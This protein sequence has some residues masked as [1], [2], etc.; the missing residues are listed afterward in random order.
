MGSYVHKRST[1]A[2]IDR[3]ARFRRWDAEMHGGLQHGQYRKR[4]AFWERLLSCWWL[5]WNTRN[6]NTLGPAQPIET[7]EPENTVNEE[8]TPSPKPNRAKS[9][10]W[11]PSPPLVWTAP[12]GEALECDNIKF[13]MP[14][15]LQTMATPSTTLFGPCGSPSALSPA[16]KK[17][18]AKSC[19]TLGFGYQYVENEAAG[20]EVLIAANNQSQI[21][22][23]QGSKQ[24]ID[25]FANFYFFQAD[26]GFNV[27]GKIHQGF[28][29]VL[30]SEWQQILDTVYAFHRPGRAIWLSG[31]SLGR[32][33]LPSPQLG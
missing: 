26:A 29:G 20:L 22:A 6:T 8:P 14:S 30:D 10:K 27:E 7:P 12:Q 4:I 33:W 18:P 28:A 13:P 23:Y 31:H 11:S 21:I 9:Q 5:V 1:S 32:R 25:W 2:Y 15:T 16:E 3:Y 17:Q 19:W 24:I